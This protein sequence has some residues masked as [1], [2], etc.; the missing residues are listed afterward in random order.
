[1]KKV[2]MAG[3]LAM[4]C[5][6]W[7][8][9]ARADE[10][11]ISSRPI[12]QDKEASIAF[13]DKNIWNWQVLDNQTVLIETNSHR[14]Y[15]ARLLSPCINLPFKDRLGFESNP[16]GS[17]DKFSTIKTGNQTCPLISLTETAAPPKKSK[18]AASATEVKP[19][20]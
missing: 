2:K 8:H 14:W 20:T 17:F 15:K 19:A 3:V 11:S 18:K 9:G 5:T 16:G 7:V 13:A 6:M 1:M 12:N 4:L 10:S